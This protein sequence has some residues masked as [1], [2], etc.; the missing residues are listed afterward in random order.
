[1]PGAIVTMTSVTTPL[2]W[3]KSTCRTASRC[4]VPGRL[5]TDVVVE[6]EDRG[7]RRVGLGVFVILT[8]QPA[9]I[10][11]ANIKRAIRVTKI[12]FFMRSALVYSSSTHKS[13]TDLYIILI[14]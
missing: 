4:T 13:G 1:V 8:V 6:V 14:K 12:R 9:A 3:L 5:A 10:T 7:E 2:Y 11:D